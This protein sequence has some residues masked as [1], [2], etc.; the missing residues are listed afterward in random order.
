MRLVTVDAEKLRNRSREWYEELYRQLKGD[1]TDK[2]FAE[3]MN[4]V[5]REHGL[6]EQNGASYASMFRTRRY[7]PND[8]ARKTLLLAA[9]DIELP[10]TGHEVVDAMVE[11]NAAWYSMLPNGDKATFVFLTDRMLEDMGLADVPEVGEHEQYTC[12]TGKSR[13]HEDE[14]K[15][16]IREAYRD[17]LN[18]M[19]EDL[20]ITWQKMWAETVEMWRRRR[21]EQTNVSELRD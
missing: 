21:M 15:V 3:A 12:N 7:L 10:P 8:D 4:A 9:D 18:R 2:A 17:D 6:K 5:A 14:V 13:G 1:M 20:G 11:P 16:W 19:R